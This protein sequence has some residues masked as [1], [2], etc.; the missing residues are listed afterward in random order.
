MDG[1]SWEEGVY[2][3]G[4]VVGTAE[5]EKATLECYQRVL[6][7]VLGLMETPPPSPQNGEAQVNGG[8]DSN[9]RSTY[10]RNMERA[11]GL[12]S[13]ILAYDAPKLH[14]M[15]FQLLEEH[16][17]SLLLRI[18]TA[19]VERYL[20][21]DPELLFRHF[22]LHKEYPKAVYVM[23]TEAHAEQGSNMHIRDRVDCLVKAISACHKCDLDSAQMVMPGWSLSHAKRQ[24][25]EDEMDV[26]LTQERLLR[27]LEASMAPLQRLKEKGRLT[28]DLEGELDERARVANEWT[29]GIAGPTE[30]YERAMAFFL[31]EGCL[32]LLQC[33]GKDEPALARKLVRSIIWREVPMYTREGE[34]SHTHAFI[35]RGRSRKGEVAVDDVRLVLDDGAA[36]EDDGWFGPLLEKTQA[37]AHELLSRKETYVLPVDTLC[38]ELQLIADEYYYA[39]HGEAEVPPPCVAASVRQAGVSPTALLDAYES[40]NRTCYPKDDEL[41]LR[42]LEVMT[43]VL[44]WACQTQQPGVLAE[45]VRPERVE[46]LAHDTMRG[47]ETVRASPRMQD[48]GAEYKIAE[49]CRQLEDKVLS[50]VRTQ[51]RYR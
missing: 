31:W 6:N 43:E 36:F 4:G 40:M 23:A 33:C 9:A 27:N 25:L 19:G 39:G 16:D 38:R 51:S 21:K 10:S 15:L 24:A 11:A 2:Q 37:L 28:E 5:R 47:L 22:M 29:W 34:A 18:K 45:S 49:L 32:Q 3:G 20:M 42:W 30:L 26:M 50:S 46:R 44:T 1:S 35:T 14:E 7:T 8:F 12:L 17:K 41:M 48:P 13:R